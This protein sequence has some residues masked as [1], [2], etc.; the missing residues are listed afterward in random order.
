MSHVQ[1]FELKTPADRNPL[2]MFLSKVVQLL[3]LHFIKKIHLAKVGE[4]DEKKIKFSQK[5]VPPAR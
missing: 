1:E 2:K 3:Y 4:R 5:T